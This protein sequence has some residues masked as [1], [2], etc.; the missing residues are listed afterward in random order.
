V[1]ASA[2]HTIVVTHGHADHAGQAPG[3]RERSGARIWMHRADAPLVRHEQPIGDADLAALVR[4]LTRYGFPPDEAEDAR[5]A[6]D[7]GL[8]RTYLLEADRLLDGGEEVAIGPYRFRIVWTPGHTP[9]HVCVYEATR[10]LMLTGDH[11]F[12]KAAPNVRLMP[13]SPPDVI[14]QYL[15]SL[16][17]IGGLEAEQALPAHGE[18][19]TNVAERVA[20]VEKHQLK[21]REHLKSLLSD[22]P[23][24]AYELAQVVWGPGARTTWDTFHGRLRRNA[25]LL[26]AAHL[27]WLAHDGEIDRLE[28]GTVQFARG[29]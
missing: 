12:G 27:E 9:G 20:Q 17:R 29:A 23:R 8:G 22:R 4:W 14:R 5:R 11:L 19:F 3:L 1:P 6:V 25:G 16:H 13:Y 21:R 26:V 15:E 28:N 2:L 7:V 10:R 18:P 24:T